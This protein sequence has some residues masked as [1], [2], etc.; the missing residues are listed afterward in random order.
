MHML[1][2]VKAGVPAE[3]KG[4]SLVCSLRF[5]CVHK[6]YRHILWRPVPTMT[7][8]GFVCAFSPRKLGWSQASPMLHKEL[9]D[10]GLM[11][12]EAQKSSSLQ[13]L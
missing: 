10:K 9:R 6:M 1:P 7:Y 2:S 5:Q 12:A 4:T 8:L 13:N 3:E 11:E